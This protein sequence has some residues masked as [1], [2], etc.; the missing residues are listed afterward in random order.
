MRH[1][2]LQ[3]T[4]HFKNAQVRIA[5]IPILYLRRF[6]IP[7]PS[8]KYA[9]V[10]LVQRIQS[11]SRLGT[12]LV[13]PYFIPIGTDKDITLTPDISPKTRM[14]E[15]GY[16]QI[17]NEGSF[18]FDGAIS[19][20]DIESASLRAYGRIVGRLNVFDGFKLGFTLQSVSDDAYVRDY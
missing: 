19:D 18:T 12:G 2:K 8:L 14:L 11:T 17:V 10:F 6:R 13:M 9:A 5:D 3:R 7:D 4:V 15:V 16:R 1:N 20:D